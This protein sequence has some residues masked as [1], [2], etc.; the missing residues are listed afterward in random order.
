MSKQYDQV[1]QNCQCSKRDLKSRNGSN[2]ENHII[3]QS[4]N[5]KVLASVSTVYNKNKTIDEKE[6]NTCVVA[7]TEVIWMNITDQSPEK[8][9]RKEVKKSLL[10]L[11]MQK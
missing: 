6:A 2:V 1:K 5:E 10:Y 7:D 3:C 8:S 11:S 9:D 4:F